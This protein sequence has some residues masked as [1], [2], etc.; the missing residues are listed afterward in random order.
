MCA[1]LPFYRKSMVRRFFG[2]KWHTITK[3]SH[4][5]TASPS[6][7]QV[8]HLATFFK[9][10]CWSTQLG[11]KRLHQL[12]STICDHYYPSPAIIEQKWLF[13]HNQ[14]TSWWALLY[15]YGL[16][17]KSLRRI[18]RQR[19]KNMKFQHQLRLFWSTI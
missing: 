16:S 4:H 8:S 3:L 14:V 18:Q 19:Q 11:K 5:V 12:W 6:N 13:F 9:F 7:P 2:R 17:C 15:L 10:A 1:D